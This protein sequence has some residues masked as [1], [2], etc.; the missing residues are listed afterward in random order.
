VASFDFA[1]LQWLFIHAGGGSLHAPIAA[2][3]AL[4]ESGGC[5]Y[6][7]AGPFDIRPVQECTYRKTVGENSFGLWQINLEAHPQYTFGNKGANLFKALVNARAAVE[8]SRQGRSFHAWSTYEN[9]AWRQ[10][11]P[12][13]VP[14]PKP[15]KEDDVLGPMMQP[16][17]D[18]SGTA[19]EHAIHE[20]WD[21]MSHELSTS[22][23]AALKR[24]AYYRHLIRKTV[25]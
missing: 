8:I 25:Q 4:A 20:A 15:A 1:E 19:K 3:I 12:G 7:L 6:A 17:V 22:L 23:P 16:G 13:K 9:G 18:T 2:A 11:M 24:S 5:Q 10:H 14:V 21:A